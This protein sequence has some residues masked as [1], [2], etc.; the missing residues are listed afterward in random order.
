[1]YTVIMLAGL[2]GLVS[3]GVDIG[4]VQVAKTELQTAADAA[5]RAAA[6]G[7]AT[8][9]AEARS[10]AVEAAAANVCDGSPVVLDPAA[11]VEIGTWDPAAKT[12]TVGSGSA[13]RVTARRIAARNTGIPL[14]FARVV[15]RDTCDIHAVAIATVQAGSSPGFTGLNGFTMLGNTLFASYNS[16]WTSTPTQFNCYQRCRVG[17]NAVID[18]R[19]NA[20]I[21]GNVVLGPSGRLAGRF[22]I[23][24]TTT[25]LASPIPTPSSPAWA[26]STNPNGISQDYTVNSFT[27]LPGGTYW[28]TSLTINALLRFSGPATVYV[29]GNITVDGPLIADDYIPANLR[30]YQI[31]SGRTFGDSGSYGMLFLIAKIEAPGANFTARNNAIVCG[32]A[33]F[34]TITTND[35]AAFFAD[36]AASQGSSARTISLVR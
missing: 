29:N 13:V 15:G 11:D 12:F 25:T 32:S 27:T 14:M 10:D 7:L 26:P 35:N 30:I 21:F 28:F 31:G 4:R 5:A 2:C 18:E 22:Y 23:S 34:N 9:A 19:Q 6:A 24:G 36:E 8:S 17:S 20:L 33:T 3:F 1:M 16:D